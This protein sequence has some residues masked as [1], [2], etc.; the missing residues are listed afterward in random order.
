MLLIGLD[1]DDTVIFTR[2][3]ASTF[4]FAEP[5][6]RFLAHCGAAP[7]DSFDI[8]VSGP[9]DSVCA[10][11]GG[12]GR[13]AGAAAAGSYWQ[14]IRPLDDATVATRRTLDAVGVALLLI[15]LG[16]LLPA[17]RRRQRVA[18]VLAASGAFAISAL[19]SGLDLPRAAE[20][21]GLLTGLLLGSSRIAWCEASDE[22]RWSV[23]ETYI[24]H[25]RAASRCPFFH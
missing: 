7:G 3:L 16:L 8:R 11:V 23:T 4:R 18:V 1:G 10:R 15:P 13:C 25:L 5:P 9:A 20:W 6:T 24:P 17:L 14:L 19:A 22:V 21:G 12:V 2:R